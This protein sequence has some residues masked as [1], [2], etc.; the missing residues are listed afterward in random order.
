MIVPVFNTK[1][2]TLSPDKIAI[3]VFL[4]IYLFRVISPFKDFLFLTYNITQLDT[5]PS[6]IAAG[7]VL[8]YL[9]VGGS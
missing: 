2:N 4:F 7:H 5:G 9:Y 1:P 6:Y 3:F 8:C